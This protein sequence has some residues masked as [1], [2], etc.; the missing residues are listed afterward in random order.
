L[1]NVLVAIAAILVF[2][3]F[4]VFTIFYKA[5]IPVAR[6]K[7]DYANGY[8]RFIELDG[9]YVHYRI[10]GKGHPLVLIHGTGASLHTWDGWTNALK[11]DFQIIRMDIPA[12]GL[13]GPNKDNEY[14]I[15]NYTTF[16]K[17]FLERLEIDSIYLA[18][19]SLGGNI[20]W[21]YTV[22]YPAQVK[23]LILIDA[24]GM[25]KK[26][27]IP[28]VFKLAKNPL[29]SWILKKVLPRSF[30][31]KNI[32]EVYYDHGKI[33]TELVDRYHS[34]ALRTGNRDAFIARANREL[35]STAPRMDKI[36]C[37]TLIQWGRH[38]QWIP[39]EDAHAFNS[40]IDRSKLI[41]YDNA[42]HVPM[43]EIPL[44]TA[45]DVRKFLLEIE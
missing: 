28:L 38:D 14:S 9:M 40:Q 25:P 22:N 34:M 15:E 44:E 7:Q 26:G 43:E 3:P 30:I 23:K 27:E 24:A 39:V 8:S 17:T 1:K 36:N 19:S 35:T 37:P 12:F 20:A 2:I 5:D 18:G 4:L 33:S 31:E 10:E 32:E 42:G 45:Q 41:I 16:L 13:T 6:L 29:T 11:N 21:N